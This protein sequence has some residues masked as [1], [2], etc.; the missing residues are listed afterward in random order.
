MVFQRSTSRPPADHHCYG[1]INKQPHL[2][3]L[4]F[5]VSLLD[6]LGNLSKNGFDY[7]PRLLLSDFRRLVPDVCHQAHLFSE[8]FS[9][10][11][12]TCSPVSPL[13][14]EMASTLHQLQEAA[15]SSVSSGLHTVGLHIIFG[16]HWSFKISC[17]VSLEPE[18]TS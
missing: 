5:I 1:G 12:H 13:D 15:G 9:A 6:R 7:Y 18:A 4:K 2:A 11:G 3:S 8:R 14:L 10:T 16:D 17:Q